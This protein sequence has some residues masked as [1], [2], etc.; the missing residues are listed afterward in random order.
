MLSFLRRLFIRPQTCPLP[1]E[2]PEAYGP[3]LSLSELQAALAD[4]PANPTL[5]ALVQ[6]MHYRRCQCISSALDAA[7]KE[8]PTAFD[9]GGAHYLDELHGEL[10]SL[11]HHTPPSEHLATWFKQ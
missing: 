4:G 8:K 9:L 3:R 2:L 11:I 6:L 10:H 7:Y 1:T 5:R